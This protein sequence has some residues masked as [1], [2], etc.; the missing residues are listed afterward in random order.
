[1]QLLLKTKGGA[2]I[3]HACMHMGPS[4]NQHVETLSVIKRVPY[5]IRRYFCGTEA[6]SWFPPA[7]SAILP[8]HKLY[9]SKNLQ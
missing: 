2:S 1:M 9:T 8:L 7:P 6:E 3:L 4:K 5:M